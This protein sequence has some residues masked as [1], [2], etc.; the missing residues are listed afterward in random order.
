MTSPP[1]ISKC[2]LRRE[3]LVRKGKLI[4][5]HQT[6]QKTCWEEINVKIL[7]DVLIPSKISSVGKLGSAVGTTTLNPTGYE[8]VHS[9][10]FLW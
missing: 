4:Y 1:N 7:K 6:A 2:Q 5:Y 10:C 3:N 9:L 8:V